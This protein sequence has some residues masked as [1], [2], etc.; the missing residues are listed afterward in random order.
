MAAIDIAKL[1]EKGLK[2]VIAKAQRLLAKKEGDAEAKFLREMRKAAAARGLDFSAMVG[3]AGGAGGAA[4]GKKAKAGS[5]AR[6][7]KLGKVAP[8]YRH[9]KQ[10]D[11]TW[12]GRGRTPK[13]VQEFKDAGKLKKITIV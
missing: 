7:R 10:P 13:W 5:S 8:K 11:L 4:A 6:G 2:R 3:G 12:S 1:D 9:P